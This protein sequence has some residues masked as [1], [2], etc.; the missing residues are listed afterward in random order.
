MS[1]VLFV[2][3]DRLLQLF[4]RVELDEGLSRRP[5]VLQVSEVNAF[6]P[7]SNLAHGEEGLEFGL[8]GGKG[9]SANAHYVIADVIHS[10]FL[11]IAKCFKVLSLKVFRVF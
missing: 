11:F 2:H 1:T 4:L 9:D 8:S 6:L 5:S 10:W 3:L 7:I